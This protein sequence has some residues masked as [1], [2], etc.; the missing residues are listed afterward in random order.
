MSPEA[1]F[2][3]LLAPHC[4]GEICFRLVRYAEL[5]E[6]W[7]R[8]HNL[9]RYASR[10][11]LVQ[12]HI[13]DS[14]AALPFLADRGRLLDIGS[15]AGFPGVPLMAARPGWTGVLLEP[16]QKR[17]AFLRLAVRELRLSADVERARFQDFGENSLWDAVTVRAIGNH[18]QILD[19]AQPRVSRG[20]Q[21]LVWTTEGGEARLREAPALGWRV[22]SSSLPG[23]ERGRLV[24]LKACST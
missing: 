15:G 16:R 14:L 12:R 11:E 1:L 23:L 4:G 6:R 7:S 2:S 18:G 8:R 9:V 19:W 5:L 22:L 24:R 3:E 10:E 21:V 13:L 20:G 17:W